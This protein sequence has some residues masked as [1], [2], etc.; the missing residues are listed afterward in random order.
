MKHRWL[1]V[2]VWFAALLVF[3]AANHWNQ[4][5]DKNTLYVFLEALGWMT[6]P[7]QL[8]L[9]AAVISGIAFSKRKPMAER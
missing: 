2:L 4:N 9:S 8:L 5:A 3:N 1:W 7:V 6:S